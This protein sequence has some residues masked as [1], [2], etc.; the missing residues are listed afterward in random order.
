MW[1]SSFL[2]HL[3]TH[4]AR[5]ERP[6]KTLRRSS[7]DNDDNGNDNAGTGGNSQTRGSGV[8]RSSSGANNNNSNNN[9]GQSSSAGGGGGYQASN[10]G[11]DV[12]SAG[13]EN[14]NVSGGH[15]E[16]NG[17]RG[18]YS[19]NGT[20]SVGGGTVGGPCVKRD[21]DVLKV[22]PSTSI[23][24]LNGLKLD[25]DHFGLESIN[26]A[27]SLCKLSGAS[28]S[29]LL[30]IN[31]DVIRDLDQRAIA[32]RRLQVEKISKGPLNIR[33][34]MIEQLQ[35]LILSTDTCPQMREEQAMG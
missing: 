27:V 34:P 1:R 32:A 19:G 4:E 5:P 18:L 16:T 13:N 17:G 26:T 29:P 6:R 20:G 3:R 8:D 35:N 22:S 21:V 28:C 23:V 9:V 31:V 33:N 2:R 11:G 15:C 14:R 24:L 10:G 30:G 25:V 12:R 7:T